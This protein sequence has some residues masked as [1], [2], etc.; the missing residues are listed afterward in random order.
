MGDNIE[1]TVIATRNG[2]LK[3]FVIGGNTEADVIPNVA[4]IQDITA[5]LNINPIAQQP[6]VQQPAPQ[7]VVQQPIVQQPAPQ[8]VQQPVMQPSMIQTKDLLL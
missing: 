7:P 2:G 5:N 4:P 1:I 6:V 8:P 3:D